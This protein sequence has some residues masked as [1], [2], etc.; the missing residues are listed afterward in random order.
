M[1]RWAPEIVLPGAHWTTL[2][3]FY[4]DLLLSLGAPDW[5]GHNLDA[6]WDSITRGGINQV[7]PPF[8]VR[9]TGVDV[10]PPECKTLLDC[11]V[12]MIAEAKAEGI[13]VEIL[14]R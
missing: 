7:N 6:L 8:R 3:D 5:H 4:R 10:M 13:P 1:R 11:F 2:E 12:A 9:V 14:C